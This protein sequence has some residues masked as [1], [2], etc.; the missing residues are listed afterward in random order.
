MAWLNGNVGAVAGLESG[1]VRGCRAVVLVR[2]V[3]VGGC[4]EDAISEGSR[5]RR[6]E[7]GGGDAVLAD[8]ERGK[9][10]QEISEGQRNVRVSQH[11]NGR[12]KV[13]RG[14]G[15]RVQVG[16]GVAGGLVFCVGDYRR[17]VFLGC[18]GIELDVGGQE[19]MDAQWAVLR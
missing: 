19:V 4:G 13:F 6:V 11:Q 2:G 16:Q 10:G 15:R 1:E 17:N 5:L 7:W 14:D 9:R 18:G 8:A 3:G 12:C